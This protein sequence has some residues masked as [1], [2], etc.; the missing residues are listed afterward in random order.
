MIWVV[1][2][3][4][5]TTNRSSS[6]FSHQRTQTRHLGCSHCPASASARQAYFETMNWIP[7]FSLGR[8][9]R[10]R[11]WRRRLIDNRCSWSLSLWLSLLLL[12]VARSLFIVAAVTIKAH[13]NTH[14]NETEAARGFSTWIGC[15]VL[16]TRSAEPAERKTKDKCFETSKLEV[17]QNQKVVHH[18]GW[19]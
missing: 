4:T 15:A 1:T 8:Q 10:R 19:G 14:K 6:C 18:Q 13:T 9:T 17:E 3:L 7:S 11:G 5:L 12:M 2:E 16:P